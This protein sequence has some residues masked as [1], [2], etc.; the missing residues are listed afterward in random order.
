MKAGH[1][2]QIGLAYEQKVPVQGEG[3]EVR[4]APADNFNNHLKV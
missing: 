4:E 3:G 1:L 2:D